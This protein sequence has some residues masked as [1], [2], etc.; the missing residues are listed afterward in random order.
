MCYFFCRRLLLKSSLTTVSISC[1][2]WFLIFL[3]YEHIYATT[4]YPLKTSWI[5][6]FVCQ[7]FNPSLLFT[8]Q[9]LSFSFSYIAPNHHPLIQKVL[10]NNYHLQFE[11]LLI[12]QECSLV[13]KMF[14][15]VLII[16]TLTEFRWLSIPLLHL[17]LEFKIHFFTNIFYSL[18]WFSN[19]CFHSKIVPISKTIF[20]FATFPACFWIRMNLMSF[21]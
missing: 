12:L 2:Y 6:V 1:E 16:F 10:C 21:D 11:I 14:F 7:A 4:L 5:S 9:E 19:N 13:Y 17:F 8:K 18:N 3:N 15:L 20:L